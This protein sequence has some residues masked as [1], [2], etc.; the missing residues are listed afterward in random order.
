[1]VEPDFLLA[2]VRIGGVLCSSFLWK[3]G[4][5]EWE[6]WMMDWWH[7]RR[8]EKTRTRL[9]WIYL[10]PDVWSGVP[11]FFSSLFIFYN[12]NTVSPKG[13]FHG[14]C[15]GKNGTY[16]GFS[17]NLFSSSSTPVSHGSD[18]VPEARFVIQGM[19]LKEYSLLLLFSTL[20]SSFVTG[21]VNSS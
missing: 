1:M 20:P 3:R 18:G 4:C 21:R 2:T 15:G 7:S 19:V 8:Q 12:Y 10:G 9:E 11:L 13:S 6:R 17:I 5:D 14:R 16:S